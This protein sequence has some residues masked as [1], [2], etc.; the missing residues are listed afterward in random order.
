MLDVKLVSGSDGTM[1]VG[2]FLAI[3]ALLIGV[4]VIRRRRKSG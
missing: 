3:A 1:I 2:M 4:V